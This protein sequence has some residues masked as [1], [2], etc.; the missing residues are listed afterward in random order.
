MSTRGRRA[1]QPAGTHRRPVPLSPGELVVEHRDRQ[2]L[3]RSYDFATLQAAPAMQRSWAVLFADACASGGG[4]DSRSTSSDNFKR[5]ARFASF[6]AGQEEP[7]GDV[8]EL[9][10]SHWTAWKVSRPATTYGYAD[11]TKVAAFLRK[12]PRLRPD[13]RAAMAKRI[14]VAKPREAAFTEAEFLE[15][16]TA[17]RR[18]FRS[19][20]RRI[21]E[22][23]QVL[24]AWRAGTLEPGSG[25]WLLGEA[26]DV[27][28]R[29]GEVPLAA[30]GKMVYRYRRPLGGG[31]I[32]AARERL[33]LNKTEVASLAVLL[34][35]EFGLNA[36]TVSEMPAPR[37]TPDSGE[38]GAP[39]Y[40]LELEKRRRG[41]GRHFETRNITDLGPGTPGR[42]I[43]QALEATALARS[44]VSAAGGPDRLLT[45]RRGRLPHAGI[46]TMEPL[47]GPFGLGLASHSY[48]E[49]AGKAQFAGAPMRRMRKTVNVL[50]RREAGQNSQDTHDRAYVVNEPRAQQA[51]VAV[52]AQGAADA[53]DAARRTVVAKLAETRRAD[54]QETATAD[55][56][57]FHSSPFSPGG[58][59]CGA[60]FLLCLACPNARVT[61]AHHP[62]LAV[63][64]QAL[65]SLNG[66]LD[67][68]TWEEDWGD[69]HARLADLRQRLGEPA[70]QAAAGK[71]T[72]SDRDIIN[73]L[74]NGNYDL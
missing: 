43:T 36:T 28:A 12:D 25:Q 16:R 69:S 1:A 50:H 10:P 17:A 52:I 62:R 58:M 39:T 8:G 13:T 54:D 46:E 21:A 63:L 51:A 2:G 41:S 68:G 23:S 38:G 49:W 29:T 20:H 31:S 73:D 9:A 19:A 45:W 74:L 22:N 7:P 14:A 64:H 6:L 40:R 67:P 60:S 3:A 4:W 65:D 72:A 18:M 70:W 47:A 34:T 35:A 30:A 56:G 26:L 42:L 55:C 5:L 44:F 57:G 61:P 37:A 32:R 24:A 27:L 59:A 11:V 53:A 66:I 71:A 15:A 48:K 33:F